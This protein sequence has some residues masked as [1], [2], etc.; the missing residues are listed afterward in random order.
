MTVDH[1][2]IG[3]TFAALLREFMS[4]SE[5]EQ[6]RKDNAAEECGIVCH[7][8]D[9][10]DANMVMQDALEIHDVDIWK[11]GGDWDN[12]DEGMRDEV[13]NLW[14]DAWDYAKKTHLTA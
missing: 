6:M 2:D 7:S 12:E 4:D 14:N 3:N 11:H 1:K 10:V 13:C 5:W 8:H 9:Y